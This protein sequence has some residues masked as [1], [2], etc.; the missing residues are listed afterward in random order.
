MLC[1]GATR[2]RL[3]SP[4]RAAVYVCGA[5]VLCGYVRAL[6]LIFIDSR[7]NS[8]DRLYNLDW[9]CCF[10]GSLV[11]CIFSETNIGGICM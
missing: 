2:V 10:A 4:A 5:C 6:V 8:T 1:V 7:I 3:H 9:I 11:L